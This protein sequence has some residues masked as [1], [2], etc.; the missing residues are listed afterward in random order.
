MEWL[1]LWGISKCRTVYSFACQFLKIANFMANG[2]YSRVAQIFL[3]AWEKRS[4][5]PRRYCWT[6]FWWH[7][8]WSRFLF[9]FHPQIVPQYAIQIRKSVFSRYDMQVLFPYVFEGK[10]QSKWAI[11]AHVVLRIVKEP[12]FDSIFTHSWHTWHYILVIKAIT[13]MSA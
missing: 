11:F 1:I 13:V 6:N 9:T 5:R 7:Q 4:R 8:N 12:I 3:Q 2:T 10:N